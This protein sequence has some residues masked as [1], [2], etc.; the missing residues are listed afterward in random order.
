MKTRR[1]QKWIDEAIASG[2]VTPLTRAELDE[3]R[4]RSLKAKADDRL[5]NA[6]MM[7]L[8]ARGARA[9]DRREAATNSKR[10]R[11]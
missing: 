10:K 4:D 3:V 9:L 11:G 1:D 6:A 7:R 8:A 5:G 2:A